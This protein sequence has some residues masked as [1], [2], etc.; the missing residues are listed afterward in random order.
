M[1]ESVP[2]DVDTWFWNMRQINIKSTPSEISDQQS[3]DARC[4]NR[5]FSIPKI[6][7]K[8]KALDC[9]L[10]GILKHVVLGK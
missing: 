10:D 8:V 1:E 9:L 5:Y 2:V 3:S 6:Q 7:D 4:K